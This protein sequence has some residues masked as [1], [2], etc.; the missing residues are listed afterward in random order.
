[1]LSCQDCERYLPVFL[2]Q[3]LEVKASLDVQAHLQDCPPC[4]DL[5][6]IEQR[7]RVF[8]RQN[9]AVPPLPDEIKQA[10]LLRAMQ[11]DGQR[12]WR[13]YLPAPARLRDF[14]LGVATAAI[15]V[16][17]VYSALPQFA[18]DSDLQK[19]VREA[20]LSYGTYTS[21]GMPPEVVSADETAVA[22]WLNTRM[23]YHIKLPGFADAATQ[24]VGGRLCR[25]WDR[26]TMALMYQRQGVPMVLFAFRGE[27]ISLPAQKSGP[28]VHI[29]HV[30]GRPVAVWQR[31]GVVYSMVGNMRPDDLVHV[32]STINYR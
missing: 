6:T 16:L 18:P 30:S 25:L 11:L 17:S 9:L 1:M 12:S 13:A 31:D 5:A 8:V 19:F 23:G 26:K 21:Q 22:Q 28:Q 4:A 32:V 29:R 3:A 27:H 15:L 24:L 10:M 2:D 14:A 20:S 7:L